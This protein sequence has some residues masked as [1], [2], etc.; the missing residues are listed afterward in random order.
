M[1]ESIVKIV[2]GADTAILFI[3]G[4]LETSD[5]CLDYMP[6]VPDD[7]SLYSMTLKGH[8][9]KVEDFS[10]ASMKEW[11]QE[12]HQVV[13]QLKATHKKLVIVTHSM[14]SLF[15]IQEAVNGMADRLFLLNAPMKVFLRPTF[16]KLLFK[17]FTNWIGP[18]DKWY[19]ESAEKYG[20]ESDYNIF[21][22][23]GWLPRMIELL[24][25][26]AKT[27]K[28]TSG[29]KVPTTMYYSKYDEMVALASVRYL[30]GNKN[31]K[32]KLL[33]NSGHLYYSPEDKKKVIDDFKKNVIQGR[34]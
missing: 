19:R 24:M 33:P 18:E 28:L 6:Y 17:V 26:I 4:V 1:I 14:G 15:A 7:W 23:F 13:G 20:I 5:F 11:E 3:H 8:G 16:F 9:G 22:Y 25:E 30:R 31:I 10:H 12:V 29:I 21:K 2:D 27:R 32:L 34:W